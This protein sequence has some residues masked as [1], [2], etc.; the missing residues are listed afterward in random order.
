MKQALLIAAAALALY[1]W[2]G[3]TGNASTA[4]TT[5]QTGQGC[6]A[7]YEARYSDHW[8]EMN[9]LQRAM[10]GLNAAGCAP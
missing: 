10:V 5:T 7:V 3:G 6:V 1:L 4:P 2:L 9:P 8:G